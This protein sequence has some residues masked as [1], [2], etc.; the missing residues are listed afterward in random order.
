MNVLIRC[1]HPEFYDAANHA[2]IEIT[3]D[4]IFML[5]KRMSITKKL[6][7]KGFL[8]TKWENNSPDF[9]PVANSADVGL[10]NM[11]KYGD[12]F[13]RTLDSN[14]Y[15]QLPDSFVPDEYAPMRPIVLTIFATKY[16][17]DSIKGGFIWTGTDKYIG[18]EGRVETY[19]MPEDTIT[20]WAKLIGVKIPECL[21]TV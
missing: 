4:L 2:V 20:E 19:E 15:I 7:E 9:I 14:D 10:A 1:F 3:E 13:D 16:S 6:W 17:D 21:Y 5:H 18:S 8:G 11:D 12:E